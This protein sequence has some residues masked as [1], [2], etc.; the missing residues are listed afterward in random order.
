MAISLTLFTACEKDPEPTPTP[1]GEDPV[2]E[3]AGGNVNLTVPAEGGTQS[4]SYS[5]TNPVDGGTIAAVS[6]ESWINGFNYDTENQIV[7]NV[8]PNEVPEAR[9]SLLT[10][11]YTY[12]DG[13]SVKKELNVIQN[14]GVAYDYEYEMT[15]FS[16]T[17]YGDMYGVNG[18]HNYYTWL[19]DMPFADGYTQP[20]GTYYLFDIYGPA[21]DNAS[22]PT[23]PAGTYVLGEWEATAEW[24]F[25]PD[26]SKAVR[27]NESSQEWGAT[28]EDGT[29]TVSYDGENVVMEA[30]LTDTE[31]KLH[32]ITYTGV[33]VLESDVPVDPGFGEDVDFSPSFAI[34][35]YAASTGSSM[36]VIFQFTDMEV[37][38][39]GYITPPGVLLA[40]DAIMPF[41]EEGNIATGTYTVSEDMT[42]FTVYPG[43]DFFGL[44]YYGT[45]ATKYVSNE[46]AY[47]A[48]VTEGT[49]EIT[50]GNGNYTIN[51][52]FVCS[53]GYKLT[54]SWS[55]DMVIGGMPGPISTLTGDYTLDLEGATAT[56]IC[57]GDYYGT[58]G[59]NWT[60]QIMPTSGPDGFIAD[61]VSE[62]A[63]FSAGIPSG[64]YTVS[65]T[66]YP[67]PGEYLEGY[68]SGSNLGGTMYVGGFTPEGYVSAY[69][70]ASSGD[71]IITNNGDGT[72][73]FTLDF[74][75][76]LGYNW[77]GEWSGSIT[78]ENQSSAS[79]VSQASRTLL[80][81]PKSRLAAEDKARIFENTI[82]KVG[83]SSVQATSS[84]FRKIAK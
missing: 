33:G 18:E 51:C 66:G 63:D 84:S 72:Y 52:D 67:A 68:L 78:L 27:Y 15:V 43:A 41:D 53:D 57:W 42:D 81:T 21:C 58:G 14:A 64:T 61:F 31:G 10:V 32:H 12:G 13:L 29:L 54:C 34:A 45:Y 77:D 79:S 38:D 23:I 25:S 76:D 37:D 24:T 46:E 22:A 19:S 40:V 47:V 16:G 36:E 69:A 2:L 5:I 71:M 82:L 65:A 48:L 35:T 80:A 6:A 39:E 70:P 1:G 55:G 20:G 60:L 59:N 50:G 49:V 26:Y 56:G 74:V 62:T 28:F 44:M 4:V 17:Y 30:F 8:D 9:S 3:L 11:T 75:D 7:F 83:D 73:H